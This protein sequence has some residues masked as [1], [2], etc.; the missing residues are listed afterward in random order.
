MLGPG[1][2]WDFLGLVAFWDWGLGFFW[3]WFWVWGWVL[4]CNVKLFL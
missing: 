3:D 4:T 2:F 1:D